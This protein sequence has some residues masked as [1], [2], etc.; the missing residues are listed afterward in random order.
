MKLSPARYISILGTEVHAAVTTAAEG[1]SALKEIRQKKNEFGLKRRALMYQQKKAKVAAEK[2]EGGRTT[3]SKSGVF[4][5][6]RRL[7][8]KVQA[9]APKRSIAELE[10]QIHD[11]DEI[12]FNLDSCKVQIE[13]KLLSLS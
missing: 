12:L 11:I 9:R 2:A 6:V 5:A 13:G 1:K 7:F 3:R 8:G 10:S 4:A